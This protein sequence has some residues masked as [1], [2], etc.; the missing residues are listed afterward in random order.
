MT[1]TFPCSA[2]RSTILL[3]GRSS[4]VKDRDQSQVQARAS[5]LAGAW[6]GGTADAKLL[7]MWGWPLEGQASVSTAQARNQ[8]RSPYTGRVSSISPL[9]SAFSVV[10][11]L[12]AHGRQIDI[13]FLSTHFLNCVTF[14]QH[15]FDTA[16]LPRECG[17]SRAYIIQLLYVDAEKSIIW[18]M[19]KSLP[20]ISSVDP[21]LDRKHI[22]LFDYV[23]GKSLILIILW[24]EC[25][26]MA[27]QG[28]NVS[29]HN[30]T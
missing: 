17:K 10:P 30:R 12:L 22:I 29:K 6:G 16:E 8:P 26:I 25:I 13:Y 5:E 14:K 19:H 4:H 20:R 2:Q 15:T 18:K 1:D 7:R 21:Y 24:K 3:Q 9:I 28:I 27:L 11:A 23:K